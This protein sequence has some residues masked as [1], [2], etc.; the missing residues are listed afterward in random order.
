MLNGFEVDVFSDQPISGKFREGGSRTIFQLSL[1]A[2]LPTQGFIGSMTFKNFIDG[3]SL[4]EKYVG[5]GATAFVPEIYNKVRNKEL[6]T[7]YLT[8]ER[9]AAL[10]AV[11]NI[12]NTP[13]ILIF[14]PNETLLR[15]ESADPFDRPE[16]LEKFLTKVTEAAKI[17]SI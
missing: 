1:P 7:P 15:I 13:A 12:K 14:S 9:V 8:K 17:I 4:S 16:R 5:E 11:L 3:I 2:P 6:I 10:N